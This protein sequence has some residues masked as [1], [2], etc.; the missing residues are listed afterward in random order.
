MHG[1]KAKWKLHKNDSCCFWTNSGSNTSQN[2]SCMATYLPSHEPN[3]TCRL[4]LEK[5]GQ[6]HKRHSSIALYIGTCQCWLTGKE[7]F[8]SALCR[9]WCS[10]ED[11]LGVMDDRDG[12]RKRVGWSCWLFSRLSGIRAG[13]SMFHGRLEAEA[14]GFSWA[15]FGWASCIIDT[16]FTLWVCP[17]FSSNNLHV[18]FGSWDGR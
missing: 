13:W 3:K 11:V 14:P 8:T 15:T 6:T 17:C 1:E 10:S 16:F 9:Y 12:W 2:S 18:L 7:L 4:L 5:Q